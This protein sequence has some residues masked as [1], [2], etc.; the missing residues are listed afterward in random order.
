VL[1]VVEEYVLFNPAEVGHFRPVAVMACP[2]QFTGLV[3]KLWH[4]EAPRG[5]PSWLTASLSLTNKE[6]AMQPNKADDLFF[7]WVVRVA[8]YYTA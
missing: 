2:H 8:A 5:P 1:L 6:N 4:S 3:K 7:L